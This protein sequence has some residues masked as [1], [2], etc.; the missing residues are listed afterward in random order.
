[1]YW[2]EESQK[3]RPTWLACNKKEETKT[4]CVVT[5]RKPR[6]LAFGRE[7][8]QYE[9]ASPDKETKETEEEPGLTR[10]QRKSLV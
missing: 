9:D 8:D 6:Q 2:D 3:R 10:R 1:M 7:G 5:S 4:T